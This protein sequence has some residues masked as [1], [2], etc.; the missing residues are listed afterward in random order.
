MYQFA[1]TPKRQRRNSNPEPEPDETISV[2]GDL[3]K[4]A[5]TWSKESGGS[6]HY[7]QMMYEE[8]MDE[9]EVRAGT[10]KAAIKELE[11][12]YYVMEA[13]KFT[14]HPDDLDEVQDVITGLRKIARS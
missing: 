8:M 11:E 12:T 6:G 14:Y 4:R 2:P 13:D 3:V 1:K 10:V 9:G 7:S 5:R